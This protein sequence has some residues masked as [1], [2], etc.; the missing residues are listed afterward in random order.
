MKVR[1]MGASHERAHGGEVASPQA[2][3]RGAALRVTPVRLAVLAV[4]AESSSAL[5]AAEIFARLSEQAGKAGGK[6]REDFDRVTVYRTLNS[7][8]EKGIAHKVDPGDRVFRFSLTDHAHCS[9]H[10]HD[11]EHPHLVCDSCGSVQC[12]PEAEVII[13]TKGGEKTGGGK[14]HAASVRP[15]DVTLHGTCGRCED[16]GESL[17]AAGKR[18]SK[19]ERR[20]KSRKDSDD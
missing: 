20:K 8:V 5:E 6:E 14:K 18:G 4:L 10:K 11:H 2:V 7:F 16:E 19:S 15:Q 13:R 3:L 17:P 9:E 12:M 1:R